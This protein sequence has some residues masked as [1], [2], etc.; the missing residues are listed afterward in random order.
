MKFHLICIVVLFCLPFHI[1][2]QN[3]F[4]KSPKNYKYKNYVYNDFKNEMTVV[5][6]RITYKKSTRNSNACKPDSLSF[7]CPKINCFEPISFSHDT[8]YYYPEQKKK[9]LFVLNEKAKQDTIHVVSFCSIKN[10]DILFE[11]KYFY[12]SIRDTIFVF[13][14]WKSQNWPQEYTFIHSSESQDNY[15]FNSVALSKRF[16]FVWI[17]YND[18]NVELEIRY[19]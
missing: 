8:I 12:S 7:G 1:K 17:K 4:E 16:G 18:H 13:K 14:L 5:D 19:Y 6:F 10:H 15:C 11:K 9:P 3:L 2:G